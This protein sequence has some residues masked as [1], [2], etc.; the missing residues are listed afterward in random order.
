MTFLTGAPS[1]VAVLAI[2]YLVAESGSRWVAL[3]AAAGLLVGLGV[4]MRREERR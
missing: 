1:F 3:V 4:A 2:V